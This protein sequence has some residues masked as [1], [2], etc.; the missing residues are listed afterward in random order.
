M[1]THTLY[2]QPRM[3]ISGIQFLSVRSQK[4]TL[5]LQWTHKVVRVV[6][7]GLIP[8]LNRSRVVS[9]HLRCSPKVLRMQLSLRIE[10]VRISLN[11]K[12]FVM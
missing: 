7:S 1:R 3:S 9:S 5:E 12:Q 11:T 4:V 10:L 6:V 2:A 8:D